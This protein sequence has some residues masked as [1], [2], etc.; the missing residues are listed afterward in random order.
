M[1][2]NLITVLLMITLPFFTFNTAQDSSSNFTPSI[3]DYYAFEKLTIEVKNYRKDRLINWS[4]FEKFSK[5]ANTIIL[6]TRSKEMYDKKHIKGAIHL[7]FSD[8]TQDNLAQIIPSFHTR[9]LIYCN[10]NIDNEPIFFASKISLPK[11]ET[12]PKPISLALNIPTFITLYGYGYKNVYELSELISSLDRKI[13]FE[14]TA[15]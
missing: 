13:T 12:Q 11:K 15:I 1:K 9:V 2:T 3:V 14:G 10:N 7:N 6:D 8:F 5:N 4:T